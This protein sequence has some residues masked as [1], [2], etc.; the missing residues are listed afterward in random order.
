MFK[1]LP[2]NALR[3]FEATARLGEIKLAAQELF[4]TPAAVSQQ[5]KKL[6]QHLQLNLWERH[7]NQIVL[8]AI[9]AQLYEVCHRSLFDLQAGIQTLRPEKRALS[10]CVQMPTTMASLWLIPRLGDFYRQYPDIDVRLLT[11]GEWRLPDSDLNIDVFLRCLPEQEAFDAQFGYE[12]LF[13][14]SMSVYASPHFY[15][16][17]AVNVI[18][19]QSDDCVYQAMNWRVWLEKYAHLGVQ[20]GQTRVFDTE[21]DAIQA[22]IAGYGLVLASDAL[23]S[24][25]VEQ[26]LLRPIF[27]QHSLVWHESYYAVYRLAR[28]RHTAV[29]TWLKWLQEQAYLQKT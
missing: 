18:A 20:V 22:A 2:L 23:V 5:L 7:A 9:G 15:W 14:E 4:V 1:D 6:E 8:T 28:Q 3:A 19:I 27:P 11:S 16:Q 21:N 24:K 12:P 29:A 25:T 10:V 17:D 26:G 13:A